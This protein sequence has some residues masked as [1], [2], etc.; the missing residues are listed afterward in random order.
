MSDAT[1]L[2]RFTGGIQVHALYISLVNLLNRRL[3]HRCLDIILRPFRVTEPHEAVDPEG[4]VRSM[5]YDLGVYGADLEEQCMIACVERNS[6]PHC[7]SKGE[8]L[9]LPPGCRCAR[10]SNQTMADIK[11]TLSTFHRTHHRQ[12][13]P[14]EFLKASKKFGL[15]GVHKPFWRNLPD[16]DIARVLSPDL[17]SWRGRIRHSPKGADTRTGRE[18]VPQGR[19]ETEAASRK[20]SSCSR[21][22]ARGRCCACADRSRRRCR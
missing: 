9:G 10:S 8:D 1:I 22:S 15:N 18:N 11:R 12:P 6:C 2:S 4:I 5:L 13:D 14:L 17:R 16:F 19:L 21:K 3:F 7:A 20:R